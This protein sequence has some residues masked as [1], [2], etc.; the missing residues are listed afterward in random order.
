MKKFIYWYKKEIIAE[1]LQY[2][3]KKLNKTKL[4][5][6]GINIE[7]I[8]PE[9]KPDAIGFSVSDEDDDYETT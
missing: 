8:E 9:Y 5:M 6:D 7:K 4:E 1:N 3:I 2:A